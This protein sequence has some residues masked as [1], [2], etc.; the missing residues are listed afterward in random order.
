MKCVDC[1]KKYI[2]QMGR[3]FNTRY[4]EHIYDIRSNNS[5]TG[6]ASHILNTDHTYGPMDDIMEIMETGKKG[7]YLNTLKK[8]HIHR[9]SKENIH[10]NEISTEA[11]NPIFE[12][13]NK[14]YMQ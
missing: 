14:I 10:M 7:K 6:Y 9:I 11:Y 4:K 12:E 8:Y 5:N 13:L 1:P 2:G 3:A